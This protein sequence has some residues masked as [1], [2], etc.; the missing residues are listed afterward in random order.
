M[1]EKKIQIS[2]SMQHC[3]GDQICVIDTETTGLIAG[4]HEIVQLCV[5]P[6]NA[7]L[8][9]RKDVMPF[10][11]LMKPDA[12]ERA[13]SEAMRVNKLEFADLNQR[14]FDQEQTKDYFE[15]WVN[16]L[17]LPYNKN[18]TRKKIIALGHNYAFDKAFIESWLGHTIYNDIFHYHYRDSMNVAAYLNDRAAFHGERVPFPKIRL[19]YVAS[20]LKIKT[21]GAHNALEDCIMCAKVYKK[22]MM[23]DLFM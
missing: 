19:T 11:V 20:Q 21:G 16:K 14:G 18:G 5:L 23:M 4:Y 15:E 10:S 7:N 6:L 12:P 8:E 9:I 17:D 3:N 22:F 2:N 1:A 13:D